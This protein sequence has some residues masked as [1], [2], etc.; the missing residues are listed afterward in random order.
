ML[1]DYKEVMGII[2]M[3]INDYF[4]KKEIDLYKE[5]KNQIDKEFQYGEDEEA[6][7][8]T[9]EK[10]EENLLILKRRVWDHD[11]QI[12]LKTGIFFLVAAFV[13]ISL[14]VLL[15]SGDRF[16]FVMI[17]A[18]VTAVMI[19]AYHMVITHICKKTNEYSRKCDLLEQK[20]KP[21]TEMI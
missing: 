9:R 8:I 4:G 14:F 18:M 11:R 6:N 12:R 19:A 2:R 16:A 3:D 5:Y 10:A 20:V 15:N 1:K 13:Y 7:R 21:P 17:T